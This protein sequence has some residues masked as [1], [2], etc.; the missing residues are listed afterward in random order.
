[1]ARSPPRVGSA[2]DTDDGT[3][4]NPDLIPAPDLCASCS[5]NDDPGQEVLCNLTRA[6]AQGEE[7]FLCFAYAPTSPNIDREAVLRELCERVG[8]E[9]PKNSTGGEDKMDE[10]D[11]RIHAILGNNNE[12]NAQ[13]LARYHSHL[14][15][16]L[17]LPLMVTGTDDF[18]WEEPYVIGGWDQQE[19]EEL[20]K[21]NPSY[22]DTFELQGIGEPDEHE[23][24]VAKVKRVSDGKVF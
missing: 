9:Y 21:T 12:R 11:K 18:P 4:F 17:S 3:E 15:K 6:D 22:T 1:M 19:Y 20:K 10:D 13:N 8:I 16:H 5:K 23:D 7:V 24:I 2:G 14:L